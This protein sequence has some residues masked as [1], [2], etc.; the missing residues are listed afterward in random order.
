MIKIKNL[1]QS[2]GDFEVLKNID[3]TIPENKI[4]A[5]IG[6]NGAG[7]STLFRSCCKIVAISTR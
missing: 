4:T 7:K 6:S 2:Y 5:I 1:S 3:L